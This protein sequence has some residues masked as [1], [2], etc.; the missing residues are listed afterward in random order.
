MDKHLFALLAPEGFADVADV[1]LDVGK[2]DPNSAHKETGATPLYLASSEGNLAV[3]KT[4]LHYRNTRHL[5]VNKPDETGRTPLYAACDKGHL[6]VV[7]LLIKAGEATA[8]SES[9]DGVTPLIAAIAGKHQKIAEV[10]VNKAGADASKGEGTSALHAAC[11]YGL[12]EIVQLLLDKGRADVNK[13]D[14]NGATAL[15]VA[16]QCGEFASAKILADAGSTIPEKFWKEL[17]EDEREE[18]QPYKLVFAFSAL[19]VIDA[20]SHIQKMTTI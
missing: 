12:G 19:N 16:L 18:M 4:L 15:V 7:K 3:V 13:L 14:L 20:L 5:D 2:A 9:N 6:D 11:Q 17:E 8:D 1:I 10:L